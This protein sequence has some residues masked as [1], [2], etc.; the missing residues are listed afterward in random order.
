MSING[1][2]T[3]IYEVDDFASAIR[4][5][6]DFGLKEEQSSENE[7][8]YRLPDG[9]SVVLRRKGD[10]DVSLQSTSE[11]G[12]REVIWGVDSKESLRALGAELQ[13]D[14]EVRED[15]DGTLHT[16]D[17]QGIAIGFRVFDRRSFESISV[18]TNGVG[19]IQRWNQSR[20]PYDRAEPKLM[21]H[22]VFGVPDV[23]TAIRFYID[24]LNFR[25]TDISRRLGVFMRCDGRNDHHN[26]FF[27]RSKSVKFHHVS[28]GVNDIDEMMA[29]SNFMQRKGW[30]SN[31]GIGRHRISSTLFYYLDNPAGGMSEYSADTDYVTDDWKPRL[32][33]P[34][35][36]NWNWLG[37]V[38]K[39]FMK[40]PEKLV[41]QLPEPIPAFAELDDFDLSSLG[42]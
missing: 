16:N 11:K 40:Q 38:T 22:V 42:E 39:G 8:K 37:V 12:V 3:L 1:I 34:L 23:D 9:S 6:G 28:F 26:L 18:P 17:D 4:F 2:A 29:G 14:R 33:D 25:I 13:T 21:H 7:V 36:G 5:Y 19:D 32:W 27:L 15:P 30:T 10:S 20:Y 41:T 35:Y 24:R 31:V